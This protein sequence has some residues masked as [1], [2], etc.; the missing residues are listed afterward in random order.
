MSGT[1]SIASKSPAQRAGI[2]CNDPQFQKFAAI[3]SGLPGQ[4]F[5]ATATAEYLRTVCGI[6]TRR[7]LDLRGTAFQ[8]FEALRTDFDAWRGRIASPRQ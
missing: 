8:K 1:R 3:R 5:N 2:L 4:Q 7:D 6:I